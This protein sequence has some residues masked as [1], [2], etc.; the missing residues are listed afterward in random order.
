MTRPDLPPAG[1]P[2][3]FWNLV[4]DPKVKTKPMRV[5]LREST[6]E[7]KGRAPVLSMSRLLVADNSIADILQAK[8]LCEELL[9]RVGQLDELVGTWEDS[10][11]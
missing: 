10:A 7:L 11:P 3:R 2:G 4:H 6:I 1:G 8:A 5:E 9:I